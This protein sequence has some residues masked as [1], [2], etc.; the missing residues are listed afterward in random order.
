MVLFAKSAL[1]K[2]YLLAQSRNFSYLIKE[3]PKVP[4]KVPTPEHTSSINLWRNIFIF[5]GIPALLAI[6]FNV[7]FLE[8]HHPKRA[9]FHPYQHMRKRNKK[10]P[11]GDGNR[12]L[13]HNEY[14]NALPEGY[15]TEDD[16][17]E[18]L[19]NEEH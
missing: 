8:E 10:F 3:L 19:H 13:F 14:Y 7:M 11:W 1:T 2:S 12:S 9:D 6:N 5:A 18:K 17:L 15:E 4:K 16:Y